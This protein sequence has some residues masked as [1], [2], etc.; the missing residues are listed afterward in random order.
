MPAEFK[1]GDIVL[2]SLEPVKGSEQG[3]TRPCIIIQN[4]IANR[5]SPVTNIIPL[6]R[7]E[8]VKKWYTCLVFLGR[9]EEGLNEDS[10][11]QCNQ[12]R[13]IDVRERAIRKVGRISGAKMRDIE[14]ALRIH[15]SL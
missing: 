15:L 11:A 13:T 14:A 6:T 1:R 8:N 5:Y 3:K 12:I 7:A 10:A 2:V 9:D 4:D